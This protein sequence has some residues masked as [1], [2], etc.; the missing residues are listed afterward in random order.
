MFLIVLPK[1][2]SRGNDME[3]FEVFPADE[4]TKS[5]DEKKKSTMIP[6]KQLRVRSSENFRAVMSRKKLSFSARKLYKN[7]ES[8][9]RFT[10]IHTRREKSK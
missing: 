5:L 6:K 1:N 9:A 10:M 7:W 2:L 8:L 4:T 3:K